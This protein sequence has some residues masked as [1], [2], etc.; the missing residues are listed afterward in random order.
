M[1]GTRQGFPPVL[2]ALE[3]G[4]LREIQKCICAQSPAEI[5]AWRIEEIRS[6]DLI[7][8]LLARRIKDV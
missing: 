2:A 7:D 3:A 5:G 1:P 6:D 4:G 8:E